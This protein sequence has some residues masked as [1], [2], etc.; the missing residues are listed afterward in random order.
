MDAWL[1]NTEGL[2]GHAHVLWLARSVLPVQEWEEVLAGMENAK[3][4]PLLMVRASQGDVPAGTSLH[5]FPQHPRTHSK[6]IQTGSKTAAGK[7]QQQHPAHLYHNLGSEV[8][9]EPPQC[10]SDPVGQ[11]Q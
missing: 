3:C 8:G 7:T 9:R 6:W 11:C 4:I 10:S 5:G 1:W 2:P